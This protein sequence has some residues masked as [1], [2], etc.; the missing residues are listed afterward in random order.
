M[1]S[2]KGWYLAFDDSVILICD[3]DYG[4]IPFGIGVRDFA[5]KFRYDKRLEGARL[6]VAK[7]RIC[8]AE[9]RID[10]SQALSL[11]KQIGSYDKN[12]L[13]NNLPHI[14]QFLLEQ[15]KSYM[16]SLLPEA[17]KIIGGT[18]IHDRQK[19][20]G[21]F[22]LTQHTRKKMSAFFR[23]LETN[24][25]TA[26]ENAVRPFLGIGRG[27]TPSSDDWMVG[28][29]YVSKRLY[30]SGAIE[31]LSNSVCECAAS[32]TNRISAAYLKSAAEG[33]WFEPLDGLLVC[34]DVPHVEAIMKI[35]SS[36]GEDMLTGCVFA[37]EYAQY[38]M[39]KQG[40]K[41]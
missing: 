40:G 25:Q 24:E 27:L 4:E 37:V 12:N 23:A 41:I 17:G 5:E 34:T 39:N 36:S 22:L 18:A 14:T 19:M 11:D 6:Y 20:T 28:F 3:A 26:I 30:S 35:G 13:Q 15:G 2:R 31:C 10:L 32:R 33:E 29:L 8:L 9:Y 38:K 16:V 1:V 7:D 21:D